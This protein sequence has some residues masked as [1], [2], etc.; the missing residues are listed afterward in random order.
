MKVLLRQRQQ[1]EK[2]VAKRR[3][4]RWKEVHKL[5]LH[6]APAVKRK[7]VADLAEKAA[8]AAKR[9]AASN[10]KTAQLQAERAVSREE[11]GRRKKEAREEKIR[12]KEEGR[13][14]REGVRLEALH[15][16]R[17]AKAFRE[18][19]ERACRVRW[20]EEQGRARTRLQRELTCSLP[21]HELAE[22]PLI[23]DILLQPSA[24]DNAAAGAATSAA[25]GAATGAAA[26]GAAGAPT[27]TSSPVA[28]SGADRA[29][30]IE[31][32]SFLQAFAK[33]LGLAPPPR[34]FVQ[35]P[36]SANASVCDKKALSSSSRQR[37]STAKKS[38]APG[39]NANP[40]VV[41]SA[42]AASAELAQR[43]IATVPSRLMAFEDFCAALAQGAPRAGWAPSLKEGGEISLRL[44]R[45]HRRL[46]ALLL[47][48]R[49]AGDLTG[50]QGKV[51][52]EPLK[53]AG[54]LLNPLTWPEVCRQVLRAAL[55]RHEQRVRSAR[56]AGAELGADANGDELVAD[57]FRSALCLPARR[58]PIAQVSVLVCT[59]TF[60]T[61]L[62][63]SLTR[64][65]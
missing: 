46:I 35:A 29:D 23:A 65:P 45:L 38:A 11:N 3:Q 17:V 31:V 33:E 59:V 60:H 4:Q 37:R 58:R 25:T 21:A 18:K 44:S 12:L 41:N 48:P 51:A 10:A 15:Q 14:Q 64:S 20:R 5:G 50:L 55:A 56:G 34:V 63:H 43:S 6:T 57:V 28:V 49:V 54:A 62:A 2:T 39:S 19:L 8:K 40:N 30:A 7:R 53:L 61:N 42:I 27:L 16:L 36:V 22:R 47:S 13:L 32:W 52:T 9:T 24:A 26:D 1:S